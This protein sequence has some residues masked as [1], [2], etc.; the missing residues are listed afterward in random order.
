[1]RRFNEFWS[2]NKMRYMN[3]ACLLM[4]LVCL[5]TILLFSGSSTSPQA[6]NSAKQPA[7]VHSRRISSAA[8]ESIDSLERQPIVRA[9]QQP[10]EELL[11]AT[12]DEGAN[13]EDE[14]NL[15][16]ERRDSP[17]PPA[18]QVNHSIK[19]KVGGESGRE[20]EQV[21]ETSGAPTST[22][23]PQED[24]ET[25]RPL[26]ESMFGANGS[27]D[28]LDEGDE[29][30][31]DQLL[32]ALRGLSNSTKPT[33]LRRRNKNGA[34]TIIISS[35]LATRNESAALSNE[36]LSSLP[37]LFEKILPQMLFRPL[38]LIGQLDRPKQMRK[39]TGFATISINSAEPQLV[40]S[41]SSLRG[42]PFGSPFESPSASSFLMPARSMP[43]PL[44][45][46]SPHAPRF[47]GFSPFEMPQLPPLGLMSMILRASA[48]GNRLGEREEPLKWNRTSLSAQAS[49][50]SQVN[51]TGNATTSAEQKSNATDVD[52]VETF[53]VGQAVRGASGGSRRGSPNS[54]LVISSSSAMSPSFNVNP[55]QQLFADS[56]LEQLPTPFGRGIFGGALQPPPAQM[57]SILRA[58]LGNVVSDLADEARQ[59][60]ASRRLVSAADD[61]NWDE[62]PLG[63]IR[64][65]RIRPASIIE[66]GQVRDTGSDESVTGAAVD[67]QQLSQV[68]G[69]GDPFELQNNLQQPFQR[70]AAVEQFLESSGSSPNGLVSGTIKQTI[71]GPGMTVERI[72]EL[73]AA[74]GQQARHMASIERVASGVR[75]QSLSRREDD[76]DDDVASNE[77]QS[78]ADSSMPVR[79]MPPP[80][81]FVRLFPFGRMFHEPSSESSEIS[82]LP[83]SPDN[84]FGRIFE[85]MRRSSPLAGEIPVLPPS[86]SIIAATRVGRR[87]QDDSDDADLDRQKRNKSRVHKYRKWPKEVNHSFRESSSSVNLPHLFNQDAP[88]Q[89]EHE[90]PFASPS[91]PLFGLPSMAVGNIATTSS[92]SNGSPMEEAKPRQF[93]YHS[94]HEIAA[95]H[96]KHAIAEAKQRD[97][98]DKGES[99]ASVAERSSFAVAADLPPPA[100]IAMGRR[101][102]D[103][104]FAAEQESSASSDAAESTLQVNG[105]EQ[106]AAMDDKRLR[107]NNLQQ[108]GAAA[109]F[110][111]PQKEYKT[112]VI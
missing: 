20:I 24:E 46:M 86:A 19:P 84:F 81:P 106:S 60:R 57:G 6:A 107:N 38:N 51:T 72:I 92:E 13:F 48:A 30:F 102:D 44:V 23:S 34:A 3:L 50:A 73:P 37:G 82:P 99:S 28:P 62:E 18:Q 55:L 101:L 43:P 109:E 29:P 1:M 15:F 96:F 68:N 76:N 71:R 26:F 91:S 80:P 95:E 69:G 67:G 103:G 22:S 59:P 98:S 74:G 111:A 66:S 2:V 53:N 41:G 65:T 54:M 64:V 87:R 94:N 78:A 104:P 25:R 12:D 75:S 88:K 27:S 35:N 90:S 61:E 9:Q 33:V 70:E 100:A 112:F 83:A 17:S 105:K 8:L 31:G 63:R 39:P 40:F 58:V 108:Q 56:Q 77:P 97:S 79:H 93:T 85:D 89:P 21:D 42:S 49:Q 16:D 110:D 32:K 5:L 52:E 7:A 4:T 10:K 36:T 47:G 14:F 45:F 11:T